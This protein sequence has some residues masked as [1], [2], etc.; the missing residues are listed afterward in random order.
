[1]PK[2]KYVKAS[3]EA[4][5]AI[6]AF[7]RRPDVLFVGN[8]YVE[9]RQPWTDRRVAEH[10]MRENPNFGLI[11]DNH[12]GSVRVTQ[13]GKTPPKMKIEPPKVAVPVQGELDLLLD[14][15]MSTNGIST[16]DVND[17]EVLFRRVEEL[18]SQV[19]FLLRQWAKVIARLDDAKPATNGTYHHTTKEITQ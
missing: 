18:E 19:E 12:V 16:I 10:L 8:K 15:V 3:I 7:L 13:F 4:R 2:S 17:R 9:Y 6:L 14:E 11:Q 1:M 5:A